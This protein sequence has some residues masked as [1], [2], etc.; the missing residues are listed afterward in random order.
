[1]ESQAVQT[2]LRVNCGLPLPLVRQVQ[3]AGFDDFESLLCLDRE[4]SKK[5]GLDETTSARIEELKLVT[6]W[7]AFI[8]SLKRDKPVSLQMI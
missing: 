3:R 1:M 2:Y 4:S 6:D 8:R 7:P 5:L